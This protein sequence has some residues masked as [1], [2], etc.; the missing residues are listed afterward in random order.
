MFTRKLFR[1]SVAVFTVAASVSFASTSAFATCFR[2]KP[3][4]VAELWACNPYKAEDGK[5]DCWVSRYAVTRDDLFYLLWVENVPWGSPMHYLRNADRRE[6]GWI[7]SAKVE[8]T[9]CFRG[10][11]ASSP[12]ARK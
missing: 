8:E 1:S 3:F 4:Q 6:V 5:K 10:R 12:A 11:K 9:G 7:D 2:V